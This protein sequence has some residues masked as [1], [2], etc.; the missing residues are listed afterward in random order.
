MHVSFFLSIF[1]PLSLSL[2]SH[3][4]SFW[5]R[6]VIVEESSKILCGWLTATSMPLS[7]SLSFFHPPS[8]LLFS[9]SFSLSTSVVSFRPALTSP[10]HLGQ[11]YFT[12]PLLLFLMSNLFDRQNM[13]LL[14]IWVLWPG[15]RVCA[16]VDATRRRICKDMYL[17]RVYSLWFSFN[18]CFR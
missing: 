9:H 6:E 16:V 5:Q 1:S 8:L 17:V 14:R 4:K 18:L 2:F 15:M 11:R 3:L 13:D 12:V 10:P 7:P